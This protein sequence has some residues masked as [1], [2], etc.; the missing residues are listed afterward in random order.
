MFKK[1]FKSP[2]ARASL[3]FQMASVSLNAELENVAR[4][5]SGET[6]ATRAPTCEPVVRQ[7][8]AENGCG[9]CLSTAMQNSG[10]WFRT[11]KTRRAPI[12]IMISN[13]RELPK[14][15]GPTEAEYDT[16]DKAL[17][18]PMHGTVTGTVPGRTLV[19]VDAPLGRREG[20]AR[21]NVPVWEPLRKRSTMSFAPDIELSNPNAAIPVLC[22]SGSQQ[23]H[24]STCKK[25]HSPLLAR[26]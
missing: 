9:L 24:P 15:F 22:I 23:L 18:K 12:F 26:R 8:R 1:R 10:N 14:R 17:P 2:C 4:P 16:G 13:P 19:E 6:G 3:L 7:R 11:C 5:C 20:F 21:K 25:Y